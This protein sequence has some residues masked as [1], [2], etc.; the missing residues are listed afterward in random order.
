MCDLSLLPS[1][2]EACRLD[3]ALLAKGYETFPATDRARLKTTQALAMSLFAERPDCEVVRRES[4]AQGF[5]QIA[6][7]V[8][9]PWALFLLPKAFADAP[10]L[11]SMLMA[12][13]LGN[14]SQIAVGL[15]TAT[16]EAIAAGTLTALELC[17][18]EHAFALE[19]SGGEAGAQTLLR[20]L[21]ADGAGRLVGVGLPHEIMATAQTLGVSAYN[22]PAQPLAAID[23]DLAPETLET[24]QRLLPGVKTFS[25]PLPAGSPRPAVLFHARTPSTDAGVLL[26]EELA[27]C[28]L[29]T[30]LTPDFFLNTSLSFTLR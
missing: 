20:L 23:P 16:P 22:A 17:G 3:D 26:S 10:R 2:I 4:A 27:G 1:G 5:V 7:R 11:T 13:R 18:I 9:A 12:A 30:A 29:E 6:T 14:V 28:W 24:I 15:L 19:D 21:A 8:P 25:L